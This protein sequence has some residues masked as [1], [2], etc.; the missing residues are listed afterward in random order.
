MVDSF[1]L[2]KEKLQF[3]LVNQLK[4]INVKFSMVELKG[5]LTSFSL[6]KI[7]HLLGH[8]WTPLLKTW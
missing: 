8:Q 5:Y 7:G 2:V 1:N 6:K 4:W 3:D